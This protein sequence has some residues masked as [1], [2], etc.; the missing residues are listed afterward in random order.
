MCFGK[1]I[2]RNRLVKNIRLILHKDNIS[3]EQLSEKVLD[4]LLELKDIDEVIFPDWKE[5]GWAKNEAIKRNIRF[6]S[7]YILS[8]IQKE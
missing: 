8:I 1:L 4:T 3:K 7:D 6:E 2:H 5:Q